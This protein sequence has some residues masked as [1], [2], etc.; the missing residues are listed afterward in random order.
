MN[1]TNNFVKVINISAEEVIKTKKEC[2]TYRKMSLIAILGGAFF[3]GI[4]VADIFE[5]LS[6][7]VKFSLIENQLKIALVFFVLA[8]VASIGSYLYFAC[9]ENAIKKIKI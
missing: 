9:K 5:E 2:S 1:D 4:T 8:L 7:V 6:K 3:L